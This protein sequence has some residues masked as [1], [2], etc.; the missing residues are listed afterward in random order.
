MIEFISEDL[1]IPSFVDSSVASWVEKVIQSHQC[2][3]GDL[4]YL[5]CSD[6]HI[7]QVNNQFL[8]HDYFTDIITFDYSSN[9]L[10]AGD[11][12]ISLDTVK[13]NSE[14]FNTSFQEELLRVIIHGVLHLIGFTDQT[15]DEK[16][17]MRAL[18]NKAL[19]LFPTFR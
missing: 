19:S 7:L 17:E 9:K 1:E 5:F 3:A 8:Q 10:I 12:V 6:Q 11:L 14:L 13:S 2:Q 4:T 16:Q 15:D 18:E